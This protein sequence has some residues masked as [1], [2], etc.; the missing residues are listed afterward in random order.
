MSKL[1]AEQPLAKTTTT[2]LIHCET[3]KMQSLFFVKFSQK[4]ATSFVA[5]G[6]SF[7]E[8]FL[9]ID[10]YEVSVAI[11]NQIDIRGQFNFYATLL[12]FH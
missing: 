10:F 2:N 7:F 1:W 4:N 12:Q 8:E 6:V 11:E 9:L 5:R 3:A